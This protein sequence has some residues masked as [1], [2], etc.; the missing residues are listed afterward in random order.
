M[1]TLIQLADQPTDIKT[2][3]RVK[4]LSREGDQLPALTY[5]I[6]TTSKGSYF[7]QTTSMKVDLNISARDEF[8][9]ASMSGALKVLDGELGYTPEAIWQTAEYYQA[10]LLAYEGQGRITAAMTRSSPGSVY[11]PAETVDICRFINL[12]AD[13]R[14]IGVISN[15]QE[16]PI[17]LNEMILRHH[18]LLGGTTG[19]GKSNTVANVA[20]AA[21]EANFVPIIYDHKPDY[22]RL[23]EPNPD[24]HAPQALDA[25]IWS[26]GGGHANAKPIYVSA[27]DLDAELLA[28]TIFHRQGEELMGEMFAAVLSGFHVLNTGRQWEWSEFIAWFNSLPGPQALAKALPSG[29]ELHKQTYDGIARRIRNNARIPNWINNLPASRA[30]QFRATAPITS[31]EAFF[32]A[33]KLSSAHVIR[34]DGQRDHHSYALFL[35]YA[36]DRIADQRRKGGPKIE[37]L[38]DEASE[39]F[40]AGNKLL[41]DHATNSLYRHIRIG[42][43][44]GIGFCLS[45]QSAGDVPPV[46]RQNLNS[47]IVFKHKHP[48]VLKDILPEQAGDLFGLINNLQRGEAMVQLFGVRGLLHARMY[49][50]PFKLFEP[51]EAQ[52]ARHTSQ[53]QANAFV[54]V[55]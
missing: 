18:L 52:P 29:I 20:A 1:K 33:I 22:I 42:R 12:P 48:S 23:N 2:A 27:S 11:R 41:R 14:P 4:L 51:D 26:L 21:K 5:L 13:G 32:D 38:I 24:C 17:R 39:L 50:S 37:H 46:V 30:P 3:D 44:L 34:L 9:P 55:E 16:L 36:L 19:M 10:Q 47:V 43:S 54:L 25:T 15:I 45:A 6:I 28:A 7:A 53:S 40:Q 31:P 35:D 8:D 49:L